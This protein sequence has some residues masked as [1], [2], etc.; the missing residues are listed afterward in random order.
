MGTSFA[1]F[2]ANFSL[3]SYEFDFLKHLLKNNTCPIVLH[4]VSLVHRFMD[5]LFVSDFPDFESFMYL[6]Q[7][8]FGGS[9]YPKTSCELNCISKGFFC[10]LLV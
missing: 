2:L 7:D 4:R 6:D 10:N 8:S 1:V 5:D 9:I 3:S